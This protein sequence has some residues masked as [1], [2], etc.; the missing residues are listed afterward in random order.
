MTPTLNRAD[1]TL[2]QREII[3]SIGHRHLKGL[4]FA[5]LCAECPLLSRPQ[6]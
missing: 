3:L 6:S 1:P 4:D 2:V 5:D